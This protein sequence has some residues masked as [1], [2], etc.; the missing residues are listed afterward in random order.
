[1]GLRLKGVAMKTGDILRRLYKYDRETF[2]HSVRVGGL[3]RKL[4]SVLGWAPEMIKKLVYAA[5]LHDIGKLEVS[6]EVLS[7][8]NPLDD[9]GFGE[10]LA[11]PLAGSLMVRPLLGDVV[12]NLVLTH[13]EPGYPRKAVR[14]VE[15]EAELRNLLRLTDKLD[16]LSS[17]RGYKEAFSKEKCR[18]ILLEEGFDRVLVDLTLSL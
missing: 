6:Q 15:E 16:A 13:H 18:G 5:L 11:H 10:I 7:S 3:C 14:G 12:A 17:P 4:A 1:M 8:P 9:F 2:Y